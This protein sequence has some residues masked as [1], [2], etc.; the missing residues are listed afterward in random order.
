[1][2]KPEG[3]RQRHLTRFDLVCNISLEPYHFK[4]LVEIQNVFPVF[5]S[6]LHGYRGLHH[7]HLD[8][9]IIFDDVTDVIVSCLPAMLVIIVW[10]R[11]QKWKHERS[12]MLSENFGTNRKI[13][14]CLQFFSIVC[15]LFLSIFGWEIKNLLCVG[16]FFFFYTL[17]LHVFANYVLLHRN[18]HVNH[19][20]YIWDS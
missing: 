14:T 20:F 1:M 15:I 11:C 13:K 3:E 5:F 10:Q 17:A 2:I 9:M 12:C 7:K 8:V 16:Y 4:E 19:M 6:H 18:E